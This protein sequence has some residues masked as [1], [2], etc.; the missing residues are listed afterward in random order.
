[1]CSLQ[2]L[3]KLYK[4]VAEVIERDVSLEIYPVFTYVIRKSK[5]PK[6]MGQER[7]VEHGKGILL[8]G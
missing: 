8:S 5:K 6:E 7:R 1:M 3:D 4:L 2:K